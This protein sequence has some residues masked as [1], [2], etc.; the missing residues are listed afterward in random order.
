MTT[1]PIADF[2]PTSISGSTSPSESKASGDTGFG[3]KLDELV[4]SRNG[5][6]GNDAE[7]TKDC[8]CPNQSSKA[9]G[10]DEGGDS[11]DKAMEALAKAI[12]M[13]AQALGGGK[14][15]KGGEEGDEIQPTGGEGKTPAKSPIAEESSSPDLKGTETVSASSQPAEAG[16][17]ELV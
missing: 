11:K 2:K 1:S 9:K 4:K 10:S 16:N 8:S 15:S 12:A 6:R 14:D 17:K 3:N 5:M 13:L 7:K